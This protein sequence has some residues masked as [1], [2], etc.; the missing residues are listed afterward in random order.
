MNKDIDFVIIQVGSNEMSLLDLKEDKSTIFDKL[1]QD[2]DKLVNISKHMVTEYDVDVFISEKPP[3]YDTKSLEQG[4]ILE[5]LNNTS[6]SILHMKTHLLDRIRVVKQTMLESK[7]DRVRSER[8]QQ[9]GLHLT[10]KGLNLLNTNW[11]DCI[12]R[13]YTDLQQNSAQHHGHLASGGGGD[14][15]AGGGGV[16]Y[17]QNRGGGNRQRRGGGNRPRFDD[18]GYYDSDIYPDNQRGGD[19]YGG[20]GFR[21]GFRGGNRDREH[22]WGGNPRGQYGGGYRNRG[23]RGG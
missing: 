4:G 2:C 15:S 8:F 16:Q 12:R 20:G 5:G 19:G 23:G 21:Q 9:D 17:Q 1:Q 11:V 14:Q 10:D 3:R 7:S 18:R 22:Q 6:N 13:V